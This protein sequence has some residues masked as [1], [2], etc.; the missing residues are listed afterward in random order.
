[1]WVNSG[2][3]YVNSGQ[4]VGEYYMLKDIFPNIKDPLVLIASAN[5]DKDT[6][7]G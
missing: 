7:N 5:K 2:T 4:I 1:M 6:Q 3:I